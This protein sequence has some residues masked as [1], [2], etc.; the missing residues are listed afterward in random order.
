MNTNYSNAAAGSSSWDY[1][2]NQSGQNLRP[3]QVALIM[4]HPDHDSAT[5]ADA[6][7]ITAEDV[8]AFRQQQGQAYGQAAHSY[9]SQGGYSDQANQDVTNAVSAY[10]LSGSGGHYGSQ[11]GGSSLPMGHPA[12][13]QAQHIGQL[14]SV[15]APATQPPAYVPISS[16]DQQSY[17][18]LE[19]QYPNIFGPKQP[20][21]PELAQFYRNQG[22]YSPGTVVHVEQDDSKVINAT[23]S[24]MSLGTTGLGPCVAICASGKTADGQ[25]IL[26]LDHSSGIFEPSAQ[27]SNLHAQMLEKGAV[28]ESIQYNLIGGMVRPQENGEV[29]GSYDQERALLALSG[30]GQGRYNIVGARLHLSQGDINSQGDRNETSVVMDKNGETIKYRK[31]SDLYAPPP[32]SPES[33]S[34]DD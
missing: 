11:P 9:S 4:S 1:G 29:Q 28:P 20:N 33:E 14:G 32:P 5:L 16:K 26:G 22:Q 27:M 31:N 21:C 25:T 12:A 19:Q 15:G 24:N 6:M 7:G 13:M 30:Q 34:D 3:E 23:T 17:K 2:N 10:D 8:D 18:Q